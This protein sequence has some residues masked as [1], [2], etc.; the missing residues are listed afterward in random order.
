MKRK[1]ERKRERKK[2]RKREREET[3]SG[4]YIERVKIDRQIIRQGEG[5]W[6][7][8]GWKNENKYDQ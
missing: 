4:K 3:Q 1:K 2:K 6:R 7:V 5:C 8:G